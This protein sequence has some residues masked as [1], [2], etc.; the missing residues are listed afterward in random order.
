MMVDAPSTPMFVRC[1]VRSAG[2]VVLVSSL[3]GCGDEPVAPTGSGSGGSGGGTSTASTTAA[4]IGGAGGGTTSSTETTGGVGGAGGSSGTAVTILNPGFEANTVAAGNYDD[5]VVPAGWVKYDPQSIIGL[6]YNSL[7]VLN[8]TGTN[9]YPGGAPQGS[10]VAL[11]FLWR[12]QTDGIPAGYSQELA[13][14][15]LP[16]THYTLRVDVGN[17]ADLGD[18]PYSLDGFPGYRVELLAGDAVIAMDD[19]TLSPPE[20]QFEES[21]VEVTTPAS[22]PEIGQPVSI[23]LLNLNKAS[24]GIEVNFDDVR[25]D[26]A[27]VGE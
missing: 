6:D 27:P 8:P 14:T 20:G 13:H 11:V 17:I 3:L 23:R 16:D 12:M 26:A 22:G 18:A 5:Q 1:A 10:N 9:L 15:L 2:V 25:L 21:L 24:S 7:G 19:D 4:A